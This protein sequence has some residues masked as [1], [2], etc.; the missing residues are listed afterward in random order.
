MR[1][2]FSKPSFDLYSICLCF[3]LF[4]QLLLFIIRCCFIFHQTCGQLDPCCNATTC[5]LKS[6]ATCRSGECCEDCLPKSTQS[7]CRAARNDCDAP[8]F[9]NGV[10]GEVCNHLTLYYLQI[11]KLIFVFVWNFETWTKELPWT[12]QNC[13]FLGVFCSPNVEKLS[14]SWLF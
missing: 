11:L 13:Y 14:L 2:Q 8:E 4:T 5:L 3:V 7:Q 1:D 10:S 6:W 9:C 12:E